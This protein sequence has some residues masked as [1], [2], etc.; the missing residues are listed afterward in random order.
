MSKVKVTLWVEETVWEEIKR[1]AFQKHQNFHGAIACEVEEAFLLL[2]WY[3]HKIT[4]KIQPLMVV[5]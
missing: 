5:I 1:L 3:A 2:D 4:Q